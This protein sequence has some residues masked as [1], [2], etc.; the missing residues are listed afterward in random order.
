MREYKAA[1]YIGRFQPLHNGHV[2]VIK[3]GL[4]IADTVIVIVGSANA[5]PNIKNPFSFEERRKMMFA[6]LE[7]EDINTPSPRVQIIG[8][9]DHYYSDNSWIAEIQVQTSKFFDEEDSVALI[10]EYKDASSNYLKSFPQWDFIPT[11]IA[12]STRGLNATNLRDSLFREDIRVDWEGKPTEG[13]LK[14]VDPIINRIPTPDGVK[15]FLKDW[16]KKPVFADICAEWQSVNNYKES[17]KSAPYPPT[18]VTT[19]AVVVC[20][21]H[22]LVVKRKFNPGKNLYALPGGF[23]KNNEVIRNAAIRELREETGIKID[24]LILDSNIVD[25]GVFDHPDR[26]L[27]GRTIT[28]AFY[29]K[30]K[31]G[32]LPDVKANDDAAEV[33]WM[34]L[35]DV[36]KN[37]EKF[38]EDHAHI[39]H[40]FTGRG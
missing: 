10:G 31:D 24:K 22:V 2:E 25:S 27:R 23:I 7:P 8:V 14:L 5:A 37:E 21:G 9:R 3:Q 30:L 39:I 32:R 29:I 12:S 13:S 20:S 11:N 4:E 26:S 6:S 19:D 38:F 15:E 40:Y 34:P 16:V 35:M 28:H 17:W 1:V 33:L 36:T 18:F